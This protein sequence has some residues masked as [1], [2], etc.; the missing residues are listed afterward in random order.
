MVKNNPNNEPQT[1]QKPKLAEE[2]YKSR[3]FPIYEMKGWSLKRFTTKM[4]VN[5]KVLKENIENK[6][7]SGVH[8]FPLSVFVPG[9]VKQP[10]LPAVRSWMR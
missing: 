3:H 8:R 5:A 10:G 6:E 1:K 2:G 9:V 4:Q 7:N